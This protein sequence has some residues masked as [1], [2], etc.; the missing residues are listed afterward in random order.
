MYKSYP[1]KFEMWTFANIE[2][3]YLL[4]Y[5][6]KETVSI[7]HNSKRKLLDRAT[8]ISSIN[9][10]IKRTILEMRIKEI[11]DEQK[12]KN[13]RKDSNQLSRITWRERARYS[14][15]NATKLS[16]PDVLSRPRYWLR[17]CY[18]HSESAGINI[19]HL[20]ANTHRRAFDSRTVKIIYRWIVASTRF[21]ISERGGA[22]ILSCA[23]HLLCVCDNIFPPADDLHQFRTNACRYNFLKIFLPITNIS[24]VERTID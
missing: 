22:R 19:Y 12:K 5:T 21:T 18:R 1:L 14:S 17:P 4:K 10:R 16:S 24:D 9:F 2:I 23:H 13:V 3:S 7:R 8:N 15:R 11:L 20:R 6:Q